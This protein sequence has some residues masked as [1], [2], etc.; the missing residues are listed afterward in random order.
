MQKE[1]ARVE[2]LA[3]KIVSAVPKFGRMERQLAVKLY[4]LLA[5]GEPV[6]PAR[7]AEALNLSETRVRDTLA[8]WPGVYYDDSGSVIGFWGLAVPEMSP[9]RFEVGG[10]TLY[11]WCAWDS[12]FIPGI[13]GK[14]ARVESADPITK[15][16]IS[17]VVGPDGVKEVAPAGTVVS[18]LSPD[19]VFGAEVVQNFCHFVHF[20]ASRETGAR[21]AAE[22]DGTFLL[23]MNE[24]FELGRLT[25]ERNFGDARVTVS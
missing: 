22:H 20:F 1:T 9:H 13:L 23:S 16:R 14:T 25:N 10:R 11:T 17:L 18:F 3:D 15:E 21:W 5:A 6:S 2:E 8:R 24:A 4:R 12:L 7:L 19:G